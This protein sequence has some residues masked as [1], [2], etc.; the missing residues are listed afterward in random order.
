M[1]TLINDIKIYDSNFE[2]L[3]KYVEKMKHDLSIPNVLSHM[4]FCKRFCDE[5][6]DCGKCN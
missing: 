3:F 6:F 4:L 1:S 2:F 5:N